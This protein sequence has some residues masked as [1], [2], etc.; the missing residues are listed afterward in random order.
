MSWP[1]HELLACPACAR[2]LDARWRCAGCGQGYGESEGVAR[3]RRPGDARTDAVRAFYAEAPF[4]GYPPHDSLTWLRARAD[5]SRFARL[6]DLAIPGD[7]RIV[8]VG[9][10][11]GQM[12]L[13]L[14]RADRQVVAADLSLDSLRLGAAAARR[15]GLGGVRFV[16]TD[17]H[18][19][20]LRKGAFDVVYCS[21][22][23]HHT[24][25]PR[26]AFGRVASLARPG[27]M[28]VLGLY[29]AMARLPLRL[30]RAVGRA[31]GFRWIPFDPVLR[32]RRHEPARR[33]AWLRDQYL[34][35]EESRHTHGE[36]LRWFAENGVDYV[37]AFPSALF[38]DDDESGL[39]D[40][41]PDRWPLEGWL[42]QLGW[43]A[44]L[45]HEGGLFVMVGR[46]REAV[47]SRGV[48]GSAIS[49][50]ETERAA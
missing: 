30:R 35:P 10:G 5:R 6:L 45:G 11:T 34:H 27:G 48:D 23:L 21:G 38:D 7:A 25:D 14:A 40:P 19:P 2:R 32:D 29:N 31:T 47:V 12:S 33:R 4:P 37:R 46:R 42:A 41:A 16:E 36:V 20:G 17:L 1:Q 49:L 15:F 18:R 39:F 22:V 26:S 13:Y 3:L 8:E 44:Q 50:P 24:P 43:M 9:C 28:I